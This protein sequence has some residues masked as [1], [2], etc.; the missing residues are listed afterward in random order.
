MDDAG[1]T[2]RR[3]VERHPEVGQ[4]VPPVPKECD[5]SYHPQSVHVGGGSFNTSDQLERTPMGCRG[6]PLR[7]GAATPRQGHQV[8]L[9]LNAGGV[10]FC[11]III[12]Y[13]LIIPWFVPTTKSVDS[14]GLSG[15]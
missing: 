13:A 3:L 15:S 1:S 11:I 4:L 10:V 5:E 9:L 8:K 7:L 2:V 12:T 6:Q 14:I